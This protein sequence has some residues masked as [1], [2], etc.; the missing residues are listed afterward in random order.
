LLIGVGL[1]LFF[2]LFINKRR[3]NKLSQIKPRT[4]STNPTSELS[5]QSFSFP[6]QNTTKYS[7]IGFNEFVLEREIGEGSYGKVYVGNWNGTHVAL[8]FC[9]NKAKVEDVINEMKLLMYIFQ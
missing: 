9:R 7:Q 4:N 5:T 3:K 2:I 8:K 6:T 1:I